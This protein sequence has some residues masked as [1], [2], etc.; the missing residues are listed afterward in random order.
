MKEFRV[1]MP[2]GVKPQFFWKGDVQDLK[3][4]ARRITKIP[5]NMQEVPTIDHRTLKVLDHL[6]VGRAVLWN[7]HLA[8][9]K[10]PQIQETNQM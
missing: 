4:T 10:M 1:W 9:M 2:P 5:I 7:M 3:L 6:T 8:P